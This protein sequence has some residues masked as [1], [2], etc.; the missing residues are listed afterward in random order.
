MLCSGCF[1][2]TVPYIWCISRRP[3]LVLRR[4]I[5]VVSQYTMLYRQTLIMCTCLES[6][7]QYM[8]S[9]AKVVVTQ[10]PAVRVTHHTRFH[11]L[12]TGA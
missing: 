11:D 3:R 5:V 6:S 1:F 9:I 12:Y 2:G 10:K 8:Y 4:V 7:N